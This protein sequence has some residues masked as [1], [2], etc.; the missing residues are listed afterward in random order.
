[1]W[2]LRAS[3]SVSGLPRQAQSRNRPQRDH[4]GE[5][6]ASAQRKRAARSPPGP[7]PTSKQLPPRRNGTTLAR[8]LPQPYRNKSGAGKCA[9]GTIQH[10]AFRV[11]NED[12]LI[13]MRDRIRSHGV[14]AIGPIGHGFCKSIYFAGPEGLCLEIA[15][16]SSA[17]DAR[18][19]IDPEVQA[20]AGISNEELA[21]FKAPAAYKG[22]GGQV[23]QPAY[24]ATK[25]HQVYPP[26]AYRMMLS[27]PDEDFT[28]R[29]SVPEP[30]VRVAAE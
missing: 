2:R 3:T 4:Q 24:D 8:F 1:M 23:K 7:H 30:P 28:K 11:P 22:E 26:D 15:T 17:I 5:R 25:P 12:G 29:F 6:T 18:A 20:L 14:P 10:I 21:R 16:S 13:A 19:W 9:A 27:M